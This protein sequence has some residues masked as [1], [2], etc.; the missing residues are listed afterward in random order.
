MIDYDLLSDAQIWL[1]ILSDKGEM[2]DLNAAEMSGPTFPD[3]ATVSSRVSGASAAAHLDGQ[4][5]GENLVGPAAF[6][7]CG[8]GICEI[9]D[10]VGL[11]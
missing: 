8:A 2:S 5:F 3:N 1:M 4:Q 9:C 11:I 6:A 7:G 10:G